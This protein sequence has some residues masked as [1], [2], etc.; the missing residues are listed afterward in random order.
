MA[1]RTNG[2][3]STVT[4]GSMAIFTASFVCVQ[5]STNAPPAPP[6]DGPVTPPVPGEPPKR[7]PPALDAPANDPLVPPWPAS[8][9][10]GTRTIREPRCSPPAPGVATP[11][12]LVPS[13]T[14]PPHAAAAIPTQ[15]AP[16]TFIQRSL[17]R[18]GTSGRRAGE[19]PA[20]N[21]DVRMTKKALVSMLLVFGCSSDP[22]NSEG[23]TSSG[24]A[25]GANASAGGAGGN[26][27]IAPGSGGA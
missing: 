19:A 12:L 1:S 22:A 17:H 10:A 25:G 9:G 13:C 6:A 14:V 26:G 21:N 8:L 27:G 3:P 15:S 16:Q 5:F 7:A 4:T 18:R 2:P 20:C 11:P 24:G 23:S